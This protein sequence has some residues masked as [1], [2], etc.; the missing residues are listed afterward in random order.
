MKLKMVFLSLGYWV[1]GFCFFLF[2]LINWDKRVHGGPFG[3]TFEGK[4]F[5]S[6]VRKT[7]KPGIFYSKGNINITICFMESSHG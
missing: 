3:K 5:E 4:K 6:S 2:L 1:F 7:Q